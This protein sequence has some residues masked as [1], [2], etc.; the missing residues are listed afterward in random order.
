MP[1]Q[2][3][4]DAPGALHHIIAR[5]NEKWKIFKDKKDYKEFIAG[6]A[7]MLICFSPR[8]RLYEPE[9]KSLP[10]LNKYFP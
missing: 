9:A 7:V 2:S 3:R 8:R 10:Q 6:I 1:R 4:I 5:G